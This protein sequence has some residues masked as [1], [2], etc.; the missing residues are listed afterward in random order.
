MRGGKLMSS[1]TTYVACL[2]QELSYMGL[3]LETMPI[4]GWG[5]DLPMVRYPMP[6]VRR[7]AGE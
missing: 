2:G 6:P 5:E 4:T 7:L 3:D 1:R